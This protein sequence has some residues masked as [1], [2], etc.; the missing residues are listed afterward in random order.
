MTENESF[1]RDDIISL[2]VPRLDR[3]RDGVESL[4]DTDAEQGDEE[5]VDDLYVYDETE[6]RAA[7]ADLDGD[8][9]DEPRLD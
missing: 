1:D 8:A 9:R 5:E 7:G 6:A 3:D 4:H 2:D